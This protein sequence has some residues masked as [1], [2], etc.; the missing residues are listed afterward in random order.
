MTLD[1]H[2]HQKQTQRPIILASAS[3][4]RAELLQ[5][6]RVTHEVMPADIDEQQYQSEPALDYVQ[7]MAHEK[8]IAVASK[9]VGRLVLAADTIVVVNQ[10][11]LGKPRDRLQAVHFLRQLSGKTHQVMTAV[12]IT[13]SADAMMVH[14]I[15]QTSRVSFMC[16]S[17]RQITDYVASDEPL[18]KAGAYAIQGLGGAFVAHLSGSYSGVMGLPLAE[19]AALLKACQAK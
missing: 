19:T 8:A 3:P 11:V 4:R 12:A 2:N 15:V 14:S 13:A 17:D 16:L 9:E 1:K 6:L 5:L 10:Q 18:G 7:R